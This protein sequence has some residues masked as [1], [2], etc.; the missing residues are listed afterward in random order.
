[1][2]YRLSG[3][4]GIGD[5]ET[6]TPKGR[7]KR[8]RGQTATPKN[9]T[10]ER[11]LRNRRIAVAAGSKE[12]SNGTSSETSSL[13]AT[14]TA[15]DS[16]R[17]RPAQDQSNGHNEETGPAAKQ[18]KTTGSSRGFFAT[19]IECAALPPPQF[20]CSE[21]GCCKRYQREAALRYH[22]SSAHPPLPN[23]VALKTSANSE[24][25][26][27]D[28]VIT[29]VV[30]SA[31]QSTTLQQQ[32][33]SDK[34]PNI[35]QNNKT[36][37]KSS[38][39]KSSVSSNSD[40]EGTGKD[41]L[42]S[43]EGNATV[44]DQPSCN[45]DTL[46]SKASDNTIS[47]SQKGASK[48][49]DSTNV[50]ASL[51]V[52]LSSDVLKSSDVSKLSDTQPSKISIISQSKGHVS[53]GNS[54]PTTNCASTINTIVASGLISN[55]VS[56][57]P[58]SVVSSVKLSPP[59]LPALT[60][61]NTLPQVSPSVTSVPTFGPTSGK[62][63]INSENKNKTSK[64]E[65]LD[66]PKAK[67]AAIKTAPVL[68]N[69]ASTS[70]RTTLVSVTTVSQVPPL[71][72][73]NLKPIQPKPT[74]MG[75]PSSVNP[76]LTDLKEMKV[77]KSKK[78]KKDK[79]RNRDVGDKD[80]SREAGDPDKER[81]SEKSIEEK[82]K[83]TTISLLQP[84]LCGEFTKPSL[85]NSPPQVKVISEPES[86]LLT[87][88]LVAE[89]PPS[90]VAPAERQSPVY[91]STNSLQEQNNKVQSPAYSDISDANDSAPSL[92]QE[93]P[94]DSVGVSSV[95]VDFLSNASPSVEDSGN[96][97]VIRSAKDAV[98]LTQKNCYSQPPSLLPVMPT[99]LSSPMDSDHRKAKAKSSSSSHRET[100]SNKNDTSQKPVPPLSSFA[101][102][103]IKRDMLMG[104]SHSHL[105][106]SISEV[107]KEPAKTRTPPSLTHINSKST[108]GQP[109]P[110]NKHDKVLNLN[111]PSQGVVTPPG[112]GRPIGCAYPM[113]ST[114][115]ASFGIKQEKSLVDND[116]RSMQQNLVHSRP[117]MLIPDRERFDGDQK[118]RERCNENR[119]ILSESLELRNQ[120]QA[121]PHQ[122]LL[123]KMPSH[124]SRSTAQEGEI[125]SKHSIDMDE[126]QKV[127]KNMGQEM[128]ERMKGDEAGKG[129]S[130]EMMDSGRTS[131]DDDQRDST[132]SKMKDNSSLKSPQCTTPK[133][134]DIPTNNNSAV[135]HGSI[136]YQ[137][138]PYPAMGAVGS[139]EGG[140]MYQ[141]MD[142]AGM[143]AMFAPQMAAFRYMIPMVDN[144][145]KDK[146]SMQMSPN[147]LSLE[148][149]GPSVNMRM[150]SF[151]A[152]NSN[153][154]SSHKLKEL[155]EIAKRNEGNAGGRSP[156]SSSSSTDIGN[157][158]AM[159]SPREGGGGT[160]PVGR[161]SPP[162]QRYV[163]EHVHHVVPSAPAGFLYSQFGR[164]F[165]VF[166][167]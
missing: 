24:T 105:H 151:D 55:V 111:N 25:R 71:A 15:S 84:P 47:D 134:R 4:F 121:P 128:K 73:A 96:R 79:D 32:P 160:T 109:F 83:P 8:G 110:A 104:Q 135:L 68:S 46:L 22:Q 56:A 17:K 33:D 125:K 26:N 122:P 41:I 148:T 39:T 152:D 59:L 89:A 119:Q 164:K 140:V 129:M 23:N 16:K 130:K 1:M 126:R 36:Q 42:T 91:L 69:P 40:K 7:A 114:P 3:E 112:S 53:I 77:K 49:S 117:P 18:S 166:Y 137:F 132:P 157:K 123:I 48:D 66:K 108:S 64:L 145:S 147:S 31:A 165:D 86:S 43:V 60:V 131:T 80:K 52:K 82:V 113:H 54:V 63:T 118:T 99:N 21:P 65:K 94:V 14:S 9:D 72:L 50:V 138:Y 98:D 10:N 19:D 35:Q 30:S 87:S 76:A 156:A 167:L 45:V 92:E 101:G 85:T 62:D 6:K 116:S 133:P 149:G 143:Y 5:I 90:L 106:S 61:T 11:R 139:I 144:A 155:K 57:V 146:P 100:S 2:Y 75:E 37:A 162:T 154:N 34:K 78:K 12:S 88:S 95:G 120:V 158:K 67:V 28:A 27:T 70:V 136:P 103:D 93:G 124:E 97:L 29:E 58:T 159:L 102:S 127:P 107:K 38:K 44:V 142:P 153:G 150:P 51:T 74:I 20:V 141:P 163:H 81:V 13:V 161:V 115:N